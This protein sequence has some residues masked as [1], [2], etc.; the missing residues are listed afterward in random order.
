MWLQI[1][2]SQV[3]IA[4]VGFVVWEELM[5]QGLMEPRLASDSTGSKGCP[6]TLDHPP[7]PRAG[8]TARHHA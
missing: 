6:G 3:F 1:I 2:S 4:L 8:F 7:C 5:K